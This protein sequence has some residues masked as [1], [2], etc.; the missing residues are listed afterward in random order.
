MPHS[1]P[2]VFSLTLTSQL[3]WPLKEIERFTLWHLGFWIEL[4]RVAQLFLPSLPVRS[5]FSRLLLYFQLARQFPIIETIASINLT[6]HVKRWLKRAKHLTLT[7]LRSHQ[8]TLLLCV[9]ERRFSK[10]LFF[11]NNL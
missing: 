5:G 8:V 9:V 10:L 1:V 7:N 3:H 6:R 4:C 2:Y 11:C